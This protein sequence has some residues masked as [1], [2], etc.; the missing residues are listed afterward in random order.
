MEQYKTTLTNDEYENLLDFMNKT[1]SCEK[2]H[3][4]FLAVYGGTSE[5]RSAFVNDIVDI[6]GVYNTHNIDSTVAMNRPHFSPTSKLTILTELSTS[7]VKFAGIIKMLVSTDEIIYD[8]AGF[9]VKYN[10]SNVVY[11]TETIQDFDSGLLK[12]AINI[13]LDNK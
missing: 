10:Q 12:R 11:V 7:N 2:I 4:K 9:N 5:I 3:N 8:C 1:V 6:I 13:N